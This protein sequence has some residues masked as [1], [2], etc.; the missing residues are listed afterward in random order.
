[1]SR[2]R[3]MRGE[4]SLKDLGERVKGERKL[5]YCRVERD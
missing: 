4:D 5:I 1:M 3:M 2:V